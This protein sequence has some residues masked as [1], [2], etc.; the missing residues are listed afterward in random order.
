[1]SKEAKVFLEHI[2][3]SICLIQTY[4]SRLSQDEFLYSTQVQDAVIRRLE[5]IGEAVKNLPM[6]L[7][8]RYTEVPWREF[9]GMRDIL[10][11][12]YFGVDL[13]LTWRVAEDDLPKLEQQIIV[14]MSEIE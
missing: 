13:E 6:E 2:L 12:K 7:R 1:M 11:H 4:I 9:A 8:E 3:E 14:I 5:I 10:I